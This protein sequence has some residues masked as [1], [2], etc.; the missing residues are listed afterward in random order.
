MV[1]IERRFVNYNLSFISSIMI[2]LVGIFLPADSDIKYRYC[3]F[4]GGKFKRWEGDSNFIRVIDTTKVKTF[5]RILE[6]KLGEKTFNFR[7]TADKTSKKVALTALESNS[8]RAKMFSA[9]GR[10]SFGDK[11]GAQDGVIMVSYFLPVILS[12][13]PSGGWSAIWDKEALLSI[14]IDVRLMWVGCVRYNG[15]PIPVE[16]EE[17]VSSALSEINCYPIFINQTMH[18]LFYDI[19]CKQNLW[20]IMHHIADVYG[21]LNLSEKSFKAQQNLWFN[22]STVLKMFR[23]KVLEV[24]Q[25]GYLIWIHGF[26]LMLLPSF[27]RRR[28]PTAKIGYFFH[29]PFPS[30]EIWRTMPR[31]EDLLRGILGADQIG[32][33]LYEY[34]RHFLTTCHRLLGYSSETNSSGKMTVNVDGR[35]VSISCIHVGVDLPRLKDIFEID[36][37]KEEILMWKERFGNRIV[38]S[39]KILLVLIS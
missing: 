12:R 35:A 31:R 39:G 17:S 2:F 18:H 29:T 8:E 13:K 37:F 21:P 19:Y 22:Y 33:H 28:L 30:S 25:Q 4:S 7:Y 34:A 24:F 14:Q 16:E 26:H 10:S 23:E 6:D 3:I 36:N 11:L 27:L 15:G 9:W 32:F 1:A 5:N 38:V 20:L